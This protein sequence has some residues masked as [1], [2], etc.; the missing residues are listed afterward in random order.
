MDDFRERAVSPA[1]NSPRDAARLNRNRA[2]EPETVEAALRLS[3]TPR[4]DDLAGL[5]DSIWDMLVPLVKQRCDRLIRHPKRREGRSH[6]VQVVCRCSGGALRTRPQAL[7]RKCLAEDAK[8]TRSE[9]ME[10]K[11][12]TLAVLDDLVEAGHTDR[13]QCPSRWSANLRKVVSFIGSIPALTDGSSLGWHSA[14]VKCQSL[15][16]LAPPRNGEELVNRARRPQRE[17]RKLTTT[18]SMAPRIDD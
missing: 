9:S 15:L 3:A 1:G 11:Q 10:G 7:S 14:V 2:V 18:G 12:L 17:G 16:G 8:R 13:S 6:F 5:V 4:T